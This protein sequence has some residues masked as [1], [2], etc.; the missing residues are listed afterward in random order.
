MTAL[1]IEDGRTWALHTDTE[2]APPTA[3]DNAIYKAY[4]EKGVAQALGR[5]QLHVVGE[6]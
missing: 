1:G 4:Y 6:P 3:R 5:K 2:V